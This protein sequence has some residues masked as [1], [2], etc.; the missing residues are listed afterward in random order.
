M[1][2]LYKL[3]KIIYY[4]LKK[5]Q[6]NKYDKSFHLAIQWDISCVKIIIE[7]FVAAIQK[8]HQN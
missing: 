4:K 8:H 7:K 2:G 5:F 6:I 3:K 1:Y